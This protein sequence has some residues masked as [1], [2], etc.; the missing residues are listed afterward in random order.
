MFDSV[1]SSSSSFAPSRNISHG[2]NTTKTTKQQLHQERNGRD[3]LLPS[4]FDSVNS[5]GGAQRQLRRRENHSQDEANDDEDDVDNDDARGGNYDGPGEDDEEEGDEE[6]GDEEG[7]GVPMSPMRI[8]IRRPARARAN[9]D[10]DH[11][12]NHQIVASAAV[13]ALRGS[14]SEDGT[15]HI[16]ISS[17][18][19]SFFS[20]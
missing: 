7:V 6:E 5:L 11:E 13:T 17:P 3:M 9:D 2:G 4:V 18:F 10:V 19:C 20:L 16:N 14:V 1:D 12:G 15:N 8:E